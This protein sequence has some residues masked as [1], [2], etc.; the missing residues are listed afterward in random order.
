[1]LRSHT[2]TDYD[3]A[4]VGAYRRTDGNDKG[5]IYHGVCRGAECELRSETG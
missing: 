3:R 4:D 5:N 1:M 2:R